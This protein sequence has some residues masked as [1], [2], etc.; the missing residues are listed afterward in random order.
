MDRL[1]I[2]KMMRRINHECG[3]AF[4]LCDE[5]AKKLGC[6]AGHS[7][8]EYIESDHVFNMGDIHGDWV[9]FQFN[10]FYILN[11][12]G[13]NSFLV[14][15][16]DI[17]DRGPEQT[18]C[19]ALVLWLKLE[20]PK[21]VWFICGNHEEE[22][23]NVNHAKGFAHQLAESSRE[24]WEH[25]LHTDIKFDINNLDH[26]IE[27][28]AHARSIW[29]NCNRY[30]K[31]LPAM[32][33]LN[34]RY[35]LTHGGIPVCFGSTAYPIDKYNSDTRL[36]SLQTLSYYDPL[37]RQCAWNDFG[38]I[39]DVSPRNDGYVD[40]GVARVV[41]YQDAKIWLKEN[42]LKCIIRGHQYPN[43]KD[44]PELSPD[45]LVY[46]IHS[47]MFMSGCDLESSILIINNGKIERLTA[48]SNLL[49][50]PIEAMI[51]YGVY[52]YRYEYDQSDDFINNIPV[53]M[54]IS[55]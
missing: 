50:S 2:L 42:N 9:T 55:T 25:I 11:N 17:I 43:G 3:Y 18:K 36:E 16:G 33:I 51:R 32:I 19:L 47:T 10:M 13:E 12:L 31:C 22:L 53:D 26:R 52:G 28:N 34:K 6:G 14:F 15:H 41:S 37:I 38:A 27:A 49:D 5:S 23:I 29:K 4:Y 35:C 30:F 46:T 7:I 1:S 24:I 40:D 48:T 8:I 21:N 20:Y 39:T 45:G 54:V 44:V